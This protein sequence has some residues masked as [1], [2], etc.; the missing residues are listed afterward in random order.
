[1]VYPSQRTDFVVFGK[2]MIGE[3]EIAEV[4]DSLRSGWVGTG[5]KVHRFETLLSD[6][7]GVEHCRCVSSCTAA[8][9]LSME[10]LG[11]GPGD[12]VLVPA[13][14]FVASANAVEHVGARP[15]FVDSERGTGLIDLDAAEAA[16]TE[17]TKA[18]MPV[19]LAGRPVDMDA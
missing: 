14:T 9:M 12:E 13:M 10:V 5:P 15:V 1:M 19:H 3:E 4:V 18:I 17:H 6:Y 8:L 11:V 2:P 16:I 7:L